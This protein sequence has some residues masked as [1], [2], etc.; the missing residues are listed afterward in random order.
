VIT[1]GTGD[2]G[3]YS[4][5][6]LGLNG[7]IDA[8]NIPASYN[9]VVAVG[10][11]SLYLGQTATRASETVWNDNGVQAFDEVNLGTPLG[12]TGGGCSTLF[13]AQGW[14]AHEAGYSSA[15]CGG[16]RLVADIS[17]VADPLTGFDIY[18]SYA[19]GSAQCPA[20]P[21]WM[22][23]GGTSL[24]SPLL[25]AAYALSGG[26]HGVPYPALTLYGHS[27]STYDVT[28]GG[29]GVCSGEGA[30]QC[31]DY[32]TNGAFDLGAGMLDCAFTPAGAV[33]PGTGACDATAGFDGPSGLGTPNSMTLF[34]KTGPTFTIRPAPKTASR[35]VSTAFGTKTPHDPFP[36]G[37]VV[38]YTWSW[39]DGT[40]STVT[41]GPTSAVTHKFTA[42]GLKTVTVT[43]RDSYG[44]TTAKTLKVTV[45]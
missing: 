2:D 39:G 14:Q 26:A 33:S 37:A 25:A 28:A 4:Y 44:V 31:P 10:G 8:P 5:D 21:T 18:D 24:S 35:N 38:K 22:T 6:W 40:P 19:C 42:T 41:N 29:N 23:L 7:V 13:G 32:S 16:K 45:S 17:M 3:Y 43:A 20:G 27:G 11:T 15:G 1:A 34:A 36:G 9:T 12:A 30:A